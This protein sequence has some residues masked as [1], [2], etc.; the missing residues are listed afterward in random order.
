MNLKEELSSMSPYERRKLQIDFMRFVA[1]M[2]APFMI[3]LL[4]H[5]VK[6]GLGW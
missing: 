3:V 1:T 6:H 5:A 2:L 4:G